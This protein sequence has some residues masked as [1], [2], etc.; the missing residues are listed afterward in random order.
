VL[1][2]GVVSDESRIDRS[3][4]VHLGQK[5]GSLQIQGRYPFLESRR[6][7]LMGLYGIFLIGGNVLRTMALSVELSDHF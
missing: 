6:N 5:T 3:V 1:W 7:S 4:F 2:F